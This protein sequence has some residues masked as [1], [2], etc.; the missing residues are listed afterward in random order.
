MEKIIIQLVTA[1]LGSVGFAFLFNVRV[2]LAI[3]GAVGGFLGW[4]IYLL[5]ESFGCGIF[6]SCL[7]AT[8]FLEL[9][10]EMLARIL[11]TPTTVIFVSSVVPLI[12][13]GSLYQTMLSAVQGDFEAF[14]NFG[15]I[16]VQYTFGLAAGMSIIWSASYIIRKVAEKNFINISKKA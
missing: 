16:T 13:G 15:Y 6:V 5:T 2:K 9:Y 12:P 4:G 8:A 7:I 10:A 3:Y 11:K 14:R 1:F